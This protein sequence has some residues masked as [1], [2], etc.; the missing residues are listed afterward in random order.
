[1]LT[2]KLR[3]H[4]DIL[5]SNVNSVVFVGICTKLYMHSIFIHCSVFTRNNKSIGFSCILYSSFFILIRNSRTTARKHN[6]TYMYR[7]FIFYWCKFKYFARN[8][9]LMGKTIFNTFYVQDLMEWYSILTYIRFADIKQPLNSI[10]HETDNYFKFKASRLR[11]GNWGT[12]NWRGGNNLAM[13]H[14]RHCWHCYNIQEPRNK[15]NRFL[16]LR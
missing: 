12:A 16:H 5:H 6:S 15:D 2:C 10:S 14:S 7:L 1:M 8:I 3:Q 13:A 4:E 11:N 9:R